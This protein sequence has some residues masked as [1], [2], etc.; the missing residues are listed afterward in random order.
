MKI[1][2]GDTL[3]DACYTEHIEYAFRTKP[4]QSQSKQ[5][6]TLILDTSAEP[7][8]GRFP[9][10]LSALVISSNRSQNP[11]QSSPKLW[12]KRSDRF[13]EA[14]HVPD[15]RL[16]GLLRTAGSL[17]QINARTGEAPGCSENNGIALHHRGHLG[18]S[19]SGTE[20]FTFGPYTG[21]D[22]GLLTIRK[23]VCQNCQW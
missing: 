19:K 17:H 22:R 18:G 3:H 2:T 6:L 8:P 16:A 20:N 9:G 12:S 1:F 21:R 11:Q 7:G 23:L 10:R 15:L 4:E 13:R 5:P 14:I